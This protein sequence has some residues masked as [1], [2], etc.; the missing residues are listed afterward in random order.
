MLEAN[1]RRRIKTYVKMGFEPVV[2]RS[3]Y[4]WCILICILALTS[5]CIAF[6]EEPGSI[7]SKSASISLSPSDSE[8]GKGVHKSYT[9]P[10]LEIIGLDA[11]INGYNRL[12]NNDQRTEDGKKVYS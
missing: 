2:W 12:A 9:V 3:G 1:Y 8:W 5:P 6:A 7:E 10:A 11:L 4:L